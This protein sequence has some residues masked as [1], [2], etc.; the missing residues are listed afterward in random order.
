MVEP[1]IGNMAL[2]C[3]VK[4]GLSGLERSLHALLPFGL[5]QGARAG[6]SSASFQHTEAFSVSHEKRSIH[7]PIF[8]KF[9]STSPLSTGIGGAPHACRRATLETALAV[10]FTLPPSLCRLAMAQPATCGV[11]AVYG[12]AI[13]LLL[14]SGGQGW[15]EVWQARCWMGSR[16]W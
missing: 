13:V 10:S 1:C 4:A 3:A 12:L 15:R 7:P 9:R 16:H 6:R 5:R 11:V 14:E 8:P 2:W